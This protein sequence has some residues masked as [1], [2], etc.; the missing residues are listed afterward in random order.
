MP[1][2]PPHRFPTNTVIITNKRSSVYTRVN[3]QQRECDLFTH[4]YVISHVTVCVY[5]PA[6]FNQIVKGLRRSYLRL[7]I[8]ILDPCT[9]FYLFIFFRRCWHRSG[10][11]YSTSGS[12]VLIYHWPVCKTHAV[13]LSRSW[14]DSVTPLCLFGSHFFLGGGSL[15]LHRR[16]GRSVGVDTA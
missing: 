14:S 1:T 9:T 12:A 7:N 10:S 2:Q 11:A 8:L 15:T 13:T 16:R 4:T 3:V 6:S 5:L